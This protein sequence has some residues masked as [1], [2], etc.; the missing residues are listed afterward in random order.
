[1]RRALAPLA[2]LVASL[3]FSVSVAECGLRLHHY[4]SLRGLSGE[5]SLRMPHASRGW[6]L[7]PDG[8]SFQRTRDYGVLVRTN[9]RGL[10]D[11]P[12]A[13]E[14]PP[15]TFRIVV[16]GDSF[17]EAYQVALE[18]SLPF[19]LQ[20]RLA[21]RGVEVV[22]LG[23]G[24]YGTAQQLLYLEEEGLRYAPDLVVLAFFAGNDISNNARA[25]ESA[26]MG[27]D[28]PTVFSRPYATASG[29]D[30]PLA[31]TPPDAE[32]MAPLA[33]RWHARRASALDALRRFF[34]PAMVVNLVEQ[35]GAQLIARLTHR[36][37]YDPSW[38][39][40]WPFLARVPL[41]EAARAWDEAWL[42]TRR[43]LLEM[44]RVA[45]GAGARFAILVVPTH[46]QVAPG[47]LAALA[48]RHPELAFDVDKL[49]RELAGFAS[50]AGIPLLDPTPELRAS[51]E[52]GT[53]VYY[54]LEDRHW[55]A[56]GHAL[57]ADR[58]AGFLDAQ[59]LL[60]QSSSTAR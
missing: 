22:N 2:L 25:I 32:R 5:H 11:R 60:P 20:E 39:F 35:A 18:E 45:R 23:V 55:N 9:D 3:A 17:M 1:M 48:E 16:L 50:S 49:G 13:L 41:P 12:H 51:Y 27:A 34:Q 36:E 43:L 57:V 56:A 54:W 28:D 53:R 52:S 15:G 4:G 30:A 47:D 6:T 29:L 46:Y 14:K 10:R 21:S 40:G 8:W 31:W 42:V 24:G 59:G 38:L 37:P 7:V 58:L 33:S 19:R 44:D 26:L